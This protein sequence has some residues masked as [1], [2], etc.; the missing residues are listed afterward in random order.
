MMT[1]EDRQ[2]RVAAENLLSG[3]VQSQRSSYQRSIS[4]INRDYVV[5]EDLIAGSRHNGRMSPVRRFFCLLVTFD[6]LF[7][8]L[9]WLI[10]TTIAGENITT[11]LIQQVVHYNIQTSLFD[12]VMLAACRFIILLL[13]YGLLYISHWWSIALTT[14]TTSAFLAAKVYMF[15]WSGVTQPGFQALLIIASFVLAWGETWF[16]DSRVVPQESQARQWIINAVDSERSPLLR[17]GFDGP[18]SRM[19][20]SVGNFFTPMDSPTHSDDEEPRAFRRRDTR[21]DEDVSNKIPTMP[22]LTLQQIDEYKRKAATLMEQAHHL[23]ISNDWKT[24]TTTLE[25]DVISAVNRSYGKVV[26]IEGI[27]EAPAS[28]LL[29]R[30]FEWVEDLPSWNKEVTD[31]KKLQ[32]IDEDTDIVYQ[33][34]K[35]FGGGL[36]GARDFITLRHRGQCGDYF[37]SS[38]VSANSDVPHRKNYIRGENGIVCWAT[39]RLVTQSD[40]KKNNCKFI[41]ILN[42]NLKGWL[43]QRVIDNALNSTMI[44]FMSS[45][46]AHVENLSPSFS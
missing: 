14:A 35:S 25:G 46:R 34:T 27:V 39:Q 16:F 31:A 18:P 15:N 44:N 22:P 28:Q 20:E 5:S 8:C 43:P 45:L 37:I 1:E 9:M 17:P 21:S 2:I 7:T 12:I 26:R 41:W 6:L 4:S 13:F 19:A 40:R 38:G 32:I 33:S 36:V 42:T 10:C 3:S 24:I 11:A 29:D 30:L 23:L